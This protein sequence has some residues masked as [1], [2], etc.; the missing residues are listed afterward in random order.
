MSNKINKIQNELRDFILK[1]LRFNLREAFKNG[2]LNRSTINEAGLRSIICNELRKWFIKRTKIKIF[3]REESTIYFR[4]EE[5]IKTCQPDIEIY[6]YPNQKKL[7]AIENFDER[8]IIAFGEIKLWGAADW[9]DYFERY[10]HSV[11]GYPK[12]WFSKSRKN[13]WNEEDLP[14]NTRLRGLF[15]DLY[16][17]RLYSDP[18]LWTALKTQKKSVPKHQ[19]KIPLRFFIY[20]AVKRHYPIFKVAN[21]IMDKREYDGKFGIKVPKSRRGFVRC[22]IRI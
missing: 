11:T 22:Y 19:R 3:T 10:S 20:C 13:Y 7:N 1:E 8:E 6:H 5:K 14:S 21:N 17:L 15:K 9:F 4:R 18:N 2:T 12:S 16:H